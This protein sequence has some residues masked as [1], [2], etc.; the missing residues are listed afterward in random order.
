MKI[1]A[2]ADTHLRTH[3]IDLPKADVLVIAGDACMS[4]G[5]NEVREFNDFLESKRVRNRYGRVLFVAGN[6]DFFFEKRP[7]EARKL[8]TNA[9]YLFDESTTI[10][11]VKFYGTPWQPLFCNWAFNMSEKKLEELYSLIPENTD[12][13]IT[14]CPPY[15][16]LDET[17]L[18]NHVG[19]YALEERVKKV[20]PKFIYLDIY[21]VRM[22][23]KKK[24]E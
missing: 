7:V 14:H 17:P 18:G 24:M 9:H 13:L 3:V 19:S 23:A 1:V 22:E 5:V 10:N 12:V 4:G 2:I 6:H 8:L 16:T 20:K 15:G 11:G 21:I